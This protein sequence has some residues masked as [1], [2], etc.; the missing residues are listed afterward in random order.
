MMIVWI[1]RYVLL[2][3][4]FAHLQRAVPIKIVIGHSFAS[5]IID[6]DRWAANHFARVRFNQFGVDFCSWQWEVNL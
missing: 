4:V 3:C 1:E 2:V 5:K 6:N